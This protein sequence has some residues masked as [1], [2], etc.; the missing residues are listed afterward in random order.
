MILL[1][2]ELFDDLDGS[3]DGLR[4]A[5]QNAIALPCQFPAECL[6]DAELW[7]DSAE[8][9]NSIT[10]D[11]ESNSLCLT[12]GLSERGQWKTYYSMRENSPALLNSELYRRVSLLVNPHL[13]SYSVG[14]T[15]SGRLPE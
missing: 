11:R 14:A 15:R 6:K 8:R 5:L 4:R 12:I 13:A 10:R 3:I 9:A 1:A 7:A 2:P